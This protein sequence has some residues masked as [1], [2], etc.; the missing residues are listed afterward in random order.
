[1]AVSFHP[2][3]NEYNATTGVYR[4]LIGRFLRVVIAV[5][6]FQKCYRYRA[7]ERFLTNRHPR[8]AESAGVRRPGE[9]L[10]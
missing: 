4:I 8:V 2:V 1:M 7:D 5:A 3:D 6:V 9:P 10:G